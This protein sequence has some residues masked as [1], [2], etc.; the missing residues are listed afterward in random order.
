[1]SKDNLERA[2]KALEKHK[3][4]KER[5]EKQ[6]KDK[7]LKDWI[8]WISVRVGI[9]LVVVTLGY[10]LITVVIP[11]FIMSF[12]ELSFG[13]ILFILFLLGLMLIALGIEFGYD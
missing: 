9:I 13:D 7:T 5:K 6:K 1:M 11:A 2:Y 12:S 10:G 4:W 8:C 3:E